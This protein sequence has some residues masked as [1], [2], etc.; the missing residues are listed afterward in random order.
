MIVAAGVFTSVAEL[1]DAIT[2]LTAQWNTNPGPFIR[3][4]TAEDIIGK[5]QRGR[6]TLNQFRSQTDH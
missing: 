5:V 4:A 6:T 3:T 2:T 1:T